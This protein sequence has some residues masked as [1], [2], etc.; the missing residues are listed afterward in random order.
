MRKKVD[1]ITHTTTKEYKKHLLTLLLQ[2]KVRRCIDL[3]VSR[4]VESFTYL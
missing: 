1:W 2:A 4:G 3:F